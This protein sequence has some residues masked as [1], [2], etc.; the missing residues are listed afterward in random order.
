MLLQTRQIFDRQAVLLFAC[1]ASMLSKTQSSIHWFGPLGPS[2]ISK[3]K[4]QGA[5]RSS[6]ATLC[7]LCRSTRFGSE[8]PFSA[9][10]KRSLIAFG[11]RLV[12]SVVGVTRSLGSWLVQAW[13]GISA[14]GVW[15]GSG[16]GVWGESNIVHPRSFEL[17]FISN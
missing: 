5:C 17:Q 7:A 12:S 15:L 4:L 11:L 9:S 2:I 16:G 6:S 10:C 8:F 13:P 3:S 1:C 14:N